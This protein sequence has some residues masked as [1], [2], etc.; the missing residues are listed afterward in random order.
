MINVSSIA[1]TPLPPLPKLPK[2]IAGYRDYDLKDPV[3][4]DNP[5]AP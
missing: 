1:L 4:C 2:W 5:L 3:E